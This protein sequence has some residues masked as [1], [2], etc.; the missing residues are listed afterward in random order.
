MYDLQVTE[1]YE[2]L[3]DEQKRK[4][5]DAYGH[6][7]LDDGGRGG[8]GGMGGMGGFGF[9]GGFA[10]FD[11]GNGRMTPEEIFEQLEQVFGGAFG[12]MGGRGG[13]RTPRGRDVQV[14]LELD[15]L[16]AAHG[17]KKTIQWHS[18]QRGQKSIE[19]DIP[20][21]VDSGMNLRL[22]D[23]GEPPRGGKGKPGHLYVAIGVRPHRTFERDGLDL[24]V[25]V[26]LTL[27]EAVLGA[28]VRGA[29]WA[30]D[31]GAISARSR[32]GLTGARADA[33]RRGEPARAARDAA[34]RPASDAGAHAHRPPAMLRQERPLRRPPQMR[35]SCAAGAWDSRH[36]RL[37]SR[38]P[39]HS[40]RGG[41]AAPRELTT[42]RAH[43]GARV[44]WS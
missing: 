4:M 39:V 38:P 31:L 20:A 40:L 18:P 33:R 43:T 24:H 16:E 15:L 42:A 14:E 44:R 6:A 26:R 41:R 8:A 22:S 11:G 27:A 10:G 36:G 17:C 12:G 30:R 32:R 7:G 21:G 2:V 37:G 35:A 25:L 23:Q 29:I 1:A 13:R 5:Y 34:E 9:P 3:S 28:S 19:V